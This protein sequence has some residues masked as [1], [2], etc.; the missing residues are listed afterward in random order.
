MLREF[1]AREQDRLEWELCSSQ[2]KDRLWPSLFSVAV[3]LPAD[4]VR[5]TPGHVLR[6]GRGLGPACHGNPSSSQGLAHPGC[7]LAPWTISS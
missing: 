7:S 5:A 2:N 3:G 1:R 6:E 4:G